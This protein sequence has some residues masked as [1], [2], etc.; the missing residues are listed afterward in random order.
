VRLLTTPLTS[1][2]VKPK[3]REL[4]KGLFDNVPSGVGSTGKLRIT[5]EELDR[6]VTEGVYWAIGRG[7]GNEED[8]K[9]CEEEGCMKGADPRNVSETAKKRGLPQF[10]TLG[11]GNHFLEVQRVEK[12]F[13]ERVAKAFGIFEDQIVVMTHCGSRGFGHQICDDYIRTMLEASR[14]YNISLP[15]KELCC[16]PVNSPEAEKYIS[17]MKCAVNY[18]FN[19]RHIIAH[20]VREVFGKMFGKNVADEMKTVY[21]VCHNI[22]KLEEHEVDGKKKMLWVHR[23][24]ATR[25]FWAGRPEIPQAYRSVGQPVII[26]GCMGTASY[27]LVGTEGGKECWG[28]T[29]FP[30]YVEVLTNRGIL[31]IKDICEL[32]E[33]GEEILVASLNEKSLQIEW[34]PVVNIF[35]RM[36]NVIRVNISQKGYAKSSYLDITPDHKVITVENSEIVEKEI[37]KLIENQEAICSLYSLKPIND[38]KLISA[39]KFAYLLGAIFTDGSIYYRKDKI[40]KVTF[41]QKNSP[42]KL[43]F[44]ERACEYFQEIFNADLSYRFTRAGEFTIRGKTYYGE[45]S[46]Y[47]CTKAKPAEILSKCYEQLEQIILRMDE[48]SLLSFIAGVAD[49]DGSYNKSLNLSKNSLKNVLHI[50]ASDPVLIKALTLAALRLGIQLQISKNRGSCYNIMIRDRLNEILNRTARFNKIECKNKIYGDKLFSVKQLL[51]VNALKAWPFREKYKANKMYDFSQFIKYYGYVRKIIKEKSEDVLK[52]LL[53]DVKMLRVKFEKELGVQEVY[54]IEVADN[55]N[56][57]V[58]TSAYRPILVKNCHGAGRTMSRNEAIRRY[59]PRDIIADLER[60]GIVCFAASRDVVSEE[61]PPAYKD[62]DEVVKS[63]ELA[64]VSKI[65]SRHVPLGVAKG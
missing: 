61:A 17:A 60:M 62:I 64:G 38:E 18:A 6:A 8:A 55:H 44:I 9:H 5:K 27:L 3:I 54:N 22:A 15:D 30:G 2:D 1:K 57:V 32:F 48:E 14:K 53:S 59:R 43:E 11:A 49:G 39:P 51:G 29:C 23:K 47:L 13:D 16:A 33:K 56:Y 28:T 24:G 19:N 35:R 12:I 58:F 20:W 10:G 52:I 63:V 7:Y 45:A 37:I 65:V 26:P 31:T 41:V 25:A 50:Y 46:Y 34:K 40:G 36:A 42:E 21:D 4:M